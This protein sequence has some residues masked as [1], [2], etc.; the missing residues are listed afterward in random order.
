[1]KNRFQH[2]DDGDGS[3]QL[4]LTSACFGDALDQTFVQVPCYEPAGTTVSL[5][6]RDL[7]SHV[8]LL[9]ASGSGKTG[10]ARWFIQQLIAYK[11]A[12]GLS[13]GVFVF[14]FNDDGTTAL[15]RRW[16]KEAGR[17][18]DIRILSSEEGHLDLFAGVHAFA[19]ITA[20]TAQLMQGPWASRSGDNAYWRETAASLIDAGLT[21]C[22][23]V[24]HEI[25][26]T[27][28]LRFL[29][30]WLVSRR[31]DA[32][33]QSLLTAFNGLRSQSN[34]GCDRVTA[35]KVSLAH[36]TVEMW[37]QL[38]LRTKSILSSCLLD[39]LAPLV[40]PET[41]HF[42]Q[43]T[44]SSAFNPEALGDGLIMVFRHSATQHPE[45]AALLGRIIKSRLWS[46]LQR[47]PI[48]PNQ[49]LC[50]VMA[51]EYH[52]IGSGGQSRASDV[53]A[54]ATLRARSVAV[55]MATQGLGH[56]ASNL[57][58]EFRALMANFSSH[59]FFRSAEDLTAELAAR[60]MG[61][62]EK[63]ISLPIEGTN[64]LQ[65]AF[66]LSTPEL[67]CPP[68]ALARLEPY[69]AFVSTPS[70]CSPNSLWLAGQHDKV[71][72]K[73]VLRRKSNGVE[74]KDTDEHSLHKSGAGGHSGS[75]LFY[76]TAEW[77]R[78]RNQPRFLVTP[79]G[80]FQEFTNLIIWAWLRGGLRVSPPVGGQRF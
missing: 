30:N 74:R 35:D 33:D 61:L 46:A 4:S 15:V 37:S 18:E 60:V 11:P 38:D 34:A 78:V 62:R 70:F 56:L 17:T 41:R 32:E 2:R 26:L 19:Q 23:T 76:D 68:G 75:R 47:R 7:C 45:S 9:G 36:A 73:S 77:E 54:L 44:K 65:Q 69:Q 10:V 49:R 25:K 39:A 27:T 5:S 42:L 48:D 6:G 71:P 31:L 50:V 22:L 24:E 13:P 16:A 1:V 43:T 40:A 51:D 79:V 67:V 72:P 14:D 3:E 58:A 52:L 53:V 12:S 8:A 63:T 28:A 55:I 21:V 59:F 57:G 64:L 29:M 20:A 80:T 66:P